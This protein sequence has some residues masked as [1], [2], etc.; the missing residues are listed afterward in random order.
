[1]TRKI[2]VVYT[3][4]CGEVEGVFEDDK[5]IATWCCNDASW[6][7]EYFAGL[8]KALGVEQVE[9]ADRGLLEEILVAHWGGD[10]D[11]AFDYE[12]ED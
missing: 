1:M 9:P 5:L 4:R 6:R 11:N 7:S 3:E 12:D 8:L 2:S 10:E